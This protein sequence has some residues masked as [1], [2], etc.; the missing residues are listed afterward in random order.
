MVRVLQ[1]QQ[2]LYVIEEAGKQARGA[3]GFG[4]MHGQKYVI[5]RGCGGGGGCYVVMCVLYETGAQGL[6]VT[7]ALLVRK[8]VGGDGAH[9][10]QQHPQQQQGQEK[11]Q[12]EQQ[13][14]LKQEAGT[15]HAWLIP[16]HAMTLLC[17]GIPFLCAESIATTGQGRSRVTGRAA[18]AG[19]HGWDH[20]CVCVC[21]S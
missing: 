1:G 6:L 13:E 16:G 15:L 19:T 7:H 18:P 5:I 21:V 14:Q 9:P 11:E 17:V 2:T 10:Q 20:V 4:A 8:E 3:V 12:Q